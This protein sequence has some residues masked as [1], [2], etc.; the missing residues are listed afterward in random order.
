M[1]ENPGHA[2]SLHIRQVSTQV[3]LIYIHEACP[4]GSDAGEL[5]RQK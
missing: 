5:S 3:D 1:L 2:Q 4:V